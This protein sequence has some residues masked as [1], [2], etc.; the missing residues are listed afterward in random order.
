MYCIVSLEEKIEDI[1]VASSDKK[2]TKA[3]LN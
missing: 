2:F 1:S 3:K